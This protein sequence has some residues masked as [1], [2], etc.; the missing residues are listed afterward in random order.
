VVLVA[1]MMK[2]DGL[3]GKEIC[4]LKLAADTVVVLLLLLLLLCW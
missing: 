1:M 4:A 2:R 3:F